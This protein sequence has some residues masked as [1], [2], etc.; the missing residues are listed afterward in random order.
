MYFID[1]LKKVF[2]LKNIGIIVWMVINLYI[3]ISFFPTTKGVT[4]GSEALVAI[5]R[6]VI[7]YAI[8]V[9]LALSPI[10][11]AIFRS[12][13]GCREIADSSILNRLT[14]LFNEIYEKA[15]L[16]DPNL[17]QNIKLYMVDQ[18]Y[19]NAFALGR[20]TV[21]VTNGLLHLDDAEIKGIFAHEF[22][23]LSNKDTDI[24][25]FIYVGNL[26][27][28]LMFLIL[29]V[30]LFIISFLMI[31]FS[32]S[33]STYETYDA[34]GRR[35][36]KKGGA[37]KGFVLAAGLD[38][39]YVAI[40]GL[41]TKL[42]IILVSHSSRNH[43]FA[44]DKFA[45]N[46]GYGRELRDALVE[47]QGETEKPTG[48]VAN[49]MATH[50]KTALRIEKLNM[51]LSGNFDDD[52][53][54]SIDEEP[55]TSNDKTDTADYNTSKTDYSSA[56]SNDMASFNKEE[57]K[58]SVDSN[59]MTSS[60][61]KNN[62]DRIFYIG[63]FASSF[64]QIIPVIL[65]KTA[66][67]LLNV[68]VIFGDKFQLY[69]LAISITYKI[70]YLFTRELYLACDIILILLSILIIIKLNKENR[71]NELKRIN[72]LSAI[73]G[74][75]MRIFIRIAS[76]YYIMDLKNLDNLCDV[77]LLISAIA[78]GILIFKRKKNNKKY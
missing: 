12:M 73:V 18:P 50:P 6:G 49:L 32:E 28:S 53:N 66:F 29:R 55:Q 56:S 21:C 33:N 46:L 17:S 14:P 62:N 38:M 48:F 1:F 52:L 9:A 25:L 77:I 58:Y 60:S 75:C 76:Y 64:I 23:H 13:N 61:Q 54:K 2:K 78:N 57:T 11:E 34:Y 47:L 8:S 74:S 26:L 40:I 7:V 59:D 67:L 42:G 72:Y 37:L 39:I 24:A 3:I 30:I 4:N 45:Y 68:G 36:R 35:Q 20:N 51:Y 22:A 10:G 44:A 15:K 43:E 69:D 70:I 63:L 41:Y 31:S 16:K 5:I 27:A 65:T 71:G 19:P